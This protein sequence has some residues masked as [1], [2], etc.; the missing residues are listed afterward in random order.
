MGTP[1][2]AHQIT[3]VLR[4]K[5]GIV[6]EG[7]LYCPLTG[8]TA[9]VQGGPWYLSCRKHPTVM[10]LPL[11][12]W[13]LYNNA[14]ALASPLYGSFTTDAGLT[15]LK[16]MVFERILEVDQKLQIPHGVSC[17]CDPGMA[18]LC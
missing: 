6:E 16:N 8:E 7:A 10:P 14:A 4:E 3:Q 2:L 15:L 5:G 1:L 13:D 11:L 9:R 18:L 12:S 17:N